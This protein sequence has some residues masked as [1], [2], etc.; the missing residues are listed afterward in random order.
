MEHVVEKVDMLLGGIEEAPVYNCLHLQTVKAELDEAAA[1]AHML[2]LLLKDCRKLVAEAVLVDNE[3]VAL[4][5][6]LVVDM[7]VEVVGR[8]QD[9][10]VEQMIWVHSLLEEGHFEAQSFVVVEAVEVGHFELESFAVVAAVLDAGIVWVI[11]VDTYAEVALKMLYDYELLLCFAARYQAL[12]QLH[13][14]SCHG[15]VVVAV[16]T[17]SAPTLVAYLVQFVTLHEPV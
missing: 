7:V 8:Q 3:K 5:E 13:L 12:V 10:V 6:V 9:K 11:V 2:V 4:M 17:L 16:E 14:S 15:Y 1:Y